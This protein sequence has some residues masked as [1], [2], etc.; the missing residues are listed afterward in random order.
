MPNLDIGAPQVTSLSLTGARLSLPLKIENANAFPLPLGGILG[1]VDIAA[2]ASAA[3]CCRRPA[4][5]PSRG[6]TTVNVPAQRQLPADGRG[7]GPGDP[8][9]RGRGEDRPRS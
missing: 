1:T 3:S 2:R 4:P 6:Q 8:H 7:R 9:R 5:V